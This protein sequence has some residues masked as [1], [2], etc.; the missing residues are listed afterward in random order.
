MGAIAMR[1]ETV[2]PLMDTGRER[3]S[4]ARDGTGWVTLTLAVSS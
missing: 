3:I 2:S 4:A 1:F